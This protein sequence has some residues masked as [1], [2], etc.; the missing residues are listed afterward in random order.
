MNIFRVHGPA[1]RRSTS[2]Y[3]RCLTSLQKSL[4]TQKN[5][6]QKM[7]NETK[8]LLDFLCLKRGAPDDD[9]SNNNVNDTCS[10]KEKK[11]KLHGLM[12]VD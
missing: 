5:T 4:T 8:Y 12:E 11:R 2:M 6:L 7:G 10:S 3:L 9:R 1:I